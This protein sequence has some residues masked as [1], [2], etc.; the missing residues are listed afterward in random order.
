MVG[1]LLGT[2]F[3]HYR[4]IPP[5]LFGELN[6]DSGTWITRRQN[7]GQNYFVETADRYPSKLDEPPLVTDGLHG[8]IFT[9]EHLLSQLFAY[10][11]VAL[12]VFGRS[13]FQI[14]FAGF[15]QKRL[16][17]VPMLIGYHAFDKHLGRQLVHQINAQSHVKTISPLGQKNKMG[18]FLGAA[19]LELVL[20]IKDL[21]SPPNKAADRALSAQVA[22]IW[23]PVK[24][25]PA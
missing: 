9:F 10:L 2:I 16:W 22:Q 6:G 12:A 17:F 1:C 15:C 24:N 18:Y 7:S 13:G 4:A 5:G 3:L 8:G 23:P 20:P 25:Y 14:A 11:S 19:L 21:E